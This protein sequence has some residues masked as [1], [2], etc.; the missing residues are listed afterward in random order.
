MSMK[1]TAFIFAL[2][3]LG[4]T[5]GRAGEIIGT[6]ELNVSDVQL[7]R[8]NG[9]DVVKIPGGYQCEEPGRPDLP[10]A[11][12]TISVPSGTQEASVEIISTEDIELPGEYVLVPAQPFFE[13]HGGTAPDWQSPDT[14]IY[15]L[16]GEYPLG[17]IDCSKVGDICGYK[18]VSLYTRPVHYIPYKK[19]LIIYKKITYKLT[20]DESGFGTIPTLSQLSVFGSLI[21]KMVSNPE[22]VAEFQ[23]VIS[24][25]GGKLPPGNHQYVIVTKSPMD[26]EF[27]RLASWKEA[28][29]YTTKVVLIDSVYSWYTAGDNCTRLKAFI[30]D[31]VNQWGALY[32]LLGGQGDPTSP[33]QNIIPTRFSKVDNS[34]YWRPCDMYYTDLDNDWNSSGYNFYGSIY[35]NVNL[36]SDVFVGRAPV[37]T[38]SQAQNFVDKVIRYEFNPP[39]SMQGKLLLTSGWLNNSTFDNWGVRTS[40]TVG[41]RLPADWDKLKLYQ[42]NGTLSRNALFDAINE[43]YEICNVVSHGDTNGL[44]WYPTPGGSHEM[45]LSSTDLN[46]IISNGD[47]A[48]FFISSSCLLAAWDLV[49]GGDCF[50]ENLINKL[51]GGFCGAIGNSRPGILGIYYLGPTLELDTVYFHN[52]AMDTLFNHIGL[53]LAADKNALL[54]I[55]FNS[56]NPYRHAYRCNL[57]SFNLLG[58]PEMSLHINTENN[59]T[60]TCPDTVGLGIDTMDVS[61]F[62]ADRPLNNAMVVLTVNG[63][64]IDLKY[65]DQTGHAALRSNTSSTDDRVVVKIFVNRILMKTVN[66]LVI[67][68]IKETTLRNI[69]VVR[70]DINDRLVWSV[71][72]SGLVKKITGCG[73]VTNVRILISG[74]DQTNWDF[75]GVSFADADNGWIVGYKNTGTDKYKGV[76]LRTANG[77]DGWIIKYST[78]T[79]LFGNTPDSLTPFLKVKTVKYGI[80]YRGYVSCGNGYILKLQIDGTWR[81]IRPPILDN[82]YISPWY[83]SLW[84]DPTAQYV[85]AGTDNRCLYAKSADGGDSWSF[86]APP[87]FDTTYSWPANT[88][89]NCHP[90]RANLAIWNKDYN[91]AYT[92]HNYGEIGQYANGNWSMHITA[93]SPTWVY[94]LDS[95]RLCGSEGFVCDHQ[96][97]EIFFE[98]RTTLYDIASWRGTQQGNVNFVPYSCA[99]GSNGRIIFEE[100]FF[101]FLD[102]NGAAMPGNQQ[103]TVCFGT[104]GSSDE[105]LYVYDIYRSSSEIDYGDLIG[106]IHPTGAGNYAYVDNTVQYSTPYHYWI[107]PVMLNGRGKWFYMG[108][109][110]PSGLSSFPLPPSPTNVVA[111]DNPGDDGNIINLSWPPVSGATG[112]LIGRKKNEEY[113]YQPFAQT[114]SCEYIDNYVTNGEVYKYAVSSYATSDRFASSICQSNSVSPSDDNFPSQVAEPCGFYDNNEKVIHLTWQPSAEPNLGG[115]WVCPEPLGKFAS[116][117]PP[118]G[119]PDDY[120]VEHSSPIDRTIYKYRVLDS[121]I[122]QTLGFA[123]TAMDRSG[124]IGPWSPTVNINTNVNTQST[125]PLATAYNNGRKLLYDKDGNLHLVYNRGDSITY[126]K[127]WD[128]G[129]SWTKGECIGVGSYPC[130]AKDSKGG[131]SAAWLHGTN[132]EYSYKHSPW[133]PP[134]TIP[135]QL[136]VMNASTPALAVGKGDTVFL[137]YIQYSHLPQDVGT[138]MCFRFPSDRFDS[139][140]IAADTLAL[141]AASGSPTITVDGRNVVHIAW[142]YNNDIFWTKRN[143]NGTWYTSGNLTNSGEVSINPSLSYYGDVH[144]L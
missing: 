105:G 113:S 93:P 36:Y 140:H 95:L 39:A 103:V 126:Q 108:S 81:V 46:N 125:S 121:Y 85:W 55:V 76:I 59:I 35:D 69:C 119:V 28:K 8:L 62:W 122:G 116:E 30:T 38:L 37:Y 128:D 6:I 27:Q 117:L 60:I 115:Y 16:P 97:N 51:N 15:N 75:K 114:L 99:V 41:N 92:G 10:M 73:D 21:K 26:A 68:P 141:F 84:T 11:V 107:R 106:T 65:T 42:K 48:G 61:V 70:Q 43:G 49:S 32:V 34:D 77:G 22:R 54:P 80:N 29:G 123:V 79:D 138:L 20:Y 100:P 50:A 144:L 74:F 96:G 58:D 132:I 120:H 83:N 33:E 63:A 7:S 13:I 135:G 31:A 66:C 82:G 25:K 53:N 57:F 78:E 109:A 17:L 118:S 137:A 45:L 56:S 90:Q 110:T 88:Y 23:P 18:V 72:D 129:Y 4:A 67:K 143:A 101:F 19:K 130:F 124:N 111:I 71:G 142:R 104:G 127:S 131:I 52:M 139:A 86:D 44:I 91:N 102:F 64:Q 87:V 2:I 89:F 47:R 98:A 94:G 3:A 1:K 12:Q 5:V 112:Y 9:Y 24:S 40:D 134:D 14:S 136:P 133:I